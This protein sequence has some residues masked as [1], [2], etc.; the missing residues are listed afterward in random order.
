MRVIGAPTPGHTNVFSPMFASAVF[1]STD[2]ISAGV[3]PGGAPTS[4]AAEP[5]STG[6]EAEVPANP[7]SPVPVPAW[8][9]R[10]SVPTPPMSGLIALKLWL[11]PRDEKAAIFP[12][13]GAAV[14]GS[15][16]AADP[17]APLVLRLF[18]SAS[19]IV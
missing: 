12:T 7:V 16:V 3:R 6:A 11:G 17:S 15:I 14:A 4:S 10:M 8:A 13:R 2:L 18:P 5:A 19:V 9:D 1:I